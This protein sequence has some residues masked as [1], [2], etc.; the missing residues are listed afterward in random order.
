MPMVKP[1]QSLSYPEQY[2]VH[3]DVD[4][5]P[6]VAIG[7][8]VVL[9]AEPGCRLVISSGVCL[10]SR[11][12]VQA[13]QGELVIE[14]GAN[15]GS[16]V[17]VVGHGRICAHAC[18]GTASTL[19]NP[20]IE[21]HRVIIPRSLITGAVAAETG[22][23]AGDSLL[24]GSGGNGPGGNG[25]GSNRV[26]M[27]GTVNQN[28]ASPV[29]PSGHSDGLPVN[30][31]HHNAA[32]TESGSESA[33]GANSTTHSP[34]SAEAAV[35]DGAEQPDSDPETNGHGATL[36]NVSQVYG[37]GQV[38]QLLETLFPHRRPLNGASAEDKT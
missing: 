23:V 13:S 19:I 32:A 15:L 37:K 30:Q 24:N 20:S 10:G 17:L 28:S 33:A 38:T 14:P 16:E 26:E 12:I 35:G 8:G 5:A 29:S 11:V 21:T 6:G 18:V 1:V 22:R 36:V 7:Q 34:P 2:Y 9:G 31:A 27:N 25:P 4:I 3:G